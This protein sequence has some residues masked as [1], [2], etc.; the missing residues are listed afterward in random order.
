MGLHKGFIF[1]L[2]ALSF[3]RCSSL[4]VKKSIYVS[5]FQRAEV[6]LDG[7]VTHLICD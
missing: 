7:V 4:N 6:V 1:V 2:T 5:M 3:S